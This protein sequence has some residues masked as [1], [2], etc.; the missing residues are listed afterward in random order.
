MKSKICNLIDALNG[1]FDD[2]VIQQKY[3]PVTELWELNVEDVSQACS[4]LSDIYDLI[5]QMG[6]NEEETFD[7]HCIF[8]KRITRIYLHYKNENI[9]EN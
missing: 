1:N 9:T 8:T 7:V 3:Y 6:I 2:G 4:V 5:D